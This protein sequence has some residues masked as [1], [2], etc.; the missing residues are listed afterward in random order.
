M[1]KEQGRVCVRPL[2]DFRDRRMFLRP[3]SVAAQVKE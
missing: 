1:E 2:R 3:A